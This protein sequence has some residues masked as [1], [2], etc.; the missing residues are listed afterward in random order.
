VA[1]TSQAWADVTVVVDASTDGSADD[2]EGVL[3]LRRARNGGKGAAVQDGL[4]RAQSDGFTHA[5]IMDADGQHPAETIAP[6]MAASLANP[7]AMILG[8]P[9]FGPEAPWVRVQGR[10]LANAC[11]AMLTGG[12]GLGDALFG[13]RVYPIRPLLEVMAETHWMRRFDFDPEAIIRL[14]WRGVRAVRT[15]VPVRYLSAE[16]G[17]VSHFRY[18]RDNFLLTWMYLRL[19]RERLSR[20]PG[21][22]P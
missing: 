8:Q 15:P 12:P 2:L 22:C 21:V 10:R 14:S 5:L 1:Q 4:L 19:I 3:V 17:G 7:D 13:L 18:G 9:A 20:R 6:M 16:E 11:T